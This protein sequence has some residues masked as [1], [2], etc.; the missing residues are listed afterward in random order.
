MKEIIQHEKKYINQRNKSMHLLNSKAKL[1]QEWTYKPPEKT[2]KLSKMLQ[3]ELSD[4]KKELEKHQKAVE[5]KILRQE[6]YIRIL[7]E[8]HAPKVDVEKQKEIEHSIQ[9]IHTRKRE[10]EVD[11]RQIGINYLSEAKKMK[12]NLSQSGFKQANEAVV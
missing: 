10:T 4:H 5:E 2:Q 8:K 7:K 1:S 6:N 11:A 12:K 3:Q 9:R